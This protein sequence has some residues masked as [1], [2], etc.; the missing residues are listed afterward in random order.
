MNANNYQQ[1]AHTYATYGN[2]SAYVFSG[3]AEECGEVCGKYAKYIRKNGGLSP[4][5]E[6]ELYVTEDF[7]GA[8]NE[9][10]VSF[11]TAIKKELGDVMWFVAECCTLYGLT[12]EDV[13]EHNLEKLADR[14][15][16]E[17]L[18]ETF[19]DALMMKRDE[20]NALVFRNRPRTGHEKKMFSKAFDAAQ[21]TM[22]NVTVLGVEKLIFTLSP[23]PRFGIVDCFAKDRDGAFWIV[24]ITDKGPAPADACYRSMPYAG[25]VLEAGHY[26][27]S[28]A[29]IRLGVWVLSGETP[30]FVEVENDRT[31]CDLKD[32]ITEETFNATCATC[33]TIDDCK[34]AF[35]PFWNTKS[36]CGRGCRFPFGGWPS[37]QIL[38]PDVPGVVCV[39]PK[40]IP[41]VQS[42]LF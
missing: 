5:T 36:S 33:H 32:V 7:G 2:N 27:P 26:I 3:L 1:E 10:D 9:E 15:A 28:N 41:M 30:R 40:A 16:R 11:R 38:V 23:V 6:D 12:L 21:K 24:G 34:A 20:A 4:L 22:A 39:V 25:W 37:R 19:A 8:I 42:S 29:T 17:R 35:G 14:K 18:R 31:Q 13:M